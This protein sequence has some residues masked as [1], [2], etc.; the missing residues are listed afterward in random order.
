M[1]PRRRL[2]A[3][4]PSD[5]KG[6]RP[7]LGL[8]SADL[9]ILVALV[10]LVSTSCSPMPEPPDDKGE[11]KRQLLQDCQTSDL[12]PSGND[13]W[14]DEEAVILVSGRCRPLFGAI[15]GPGSDIIIRANE[16]I[17]AQ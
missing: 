2:G 5:P 9:K 13:S 16:S 6:R 14:S 12:R 1:T 3:W 8:S 4:A 15:T 11:L 17:W 10:L 7:R